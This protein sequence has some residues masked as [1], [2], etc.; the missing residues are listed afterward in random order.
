MLWTHIFLFVQHNIIYNFNACDANKPPTQNDRPLLERCVLHMR[1]LYA[2]KFAEAAWCDSDWLWLLCTYIYVATWNN[3]NN[4][5]PGHCCCVCWII[6]IYM[7]LTCSKNFFGGKIT[8]GKI[9]IQHALII[10]SNI[11]Y[12]NSNI[13]FWSFYF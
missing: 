9:F 6:Y 4:H 11:Y 10:Y 1:W 2:Y 7:N 3:W 5:C 12:G 13:Y 8:W